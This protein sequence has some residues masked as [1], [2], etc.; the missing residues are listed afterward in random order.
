M[1]WNDQQLTAIAGILEFI[2]KP[3]DQSDPTGWAVLLDGFAGTGK[4]TLVQEALNQAITLNPKLQVCVTAP[5]NRATQVLR[6]FGKDAGINVDS[7]TIH[8]LLGLLLGSEGEARKCFRGSEGNFGQYHIVIIDEASIE[9]YL[10]MDTTTESALKY[11]VKVVF[12]GD[13]CQLNPPKESTSRVFDPKEVP[14]RFRLTINERVDKDSPVNQAIVASRARVQSYLDIDTAYNEKVA[15]MSKDDFKAQERKLL[16]EKSIAYQN[17]PIPLEETKLTEN[18]DGV[19]I[20]QGKE[21]YD[22]MLDQFDCEEFQNDI[23]FCR[24]LAWTNREVDRLNHM[25][26]QRIYG[27]CCADFIIGETL[28]IL[29]PVLDTEGVPVIFTDEE[30]VIESIGTGAI[31][32]KDDFDTLA[33]GHPKYVVWVLQLR[34]PDNRGTHRIATLHS[35]SIY[36]FNGRL[37][38]LKDRAIKKTGL[39]KKFYQFKEL[40]TVVRPIYAQTVH[41]AQGQTFNTTFLQ[42]RDI[43]KNNNLLEQ[44][45]LDYV[46]KSRTTTNLVLN[47]KQ[48]R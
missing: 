23:T 36:N 14:T 7:G 20:I 34:L 39:W 37:K 12:M 45:R 29:T 19:H 42:C 30:C 11:G 43:A 32:D 16:R 5:T 17:V 41:K 1:K 46:G 38:R 26:R 22:T 48:L 15:L 33:E 28:S 35:D 8:S 13:I 44:A 4:T 9:G 24:V 47:L 27:K 18:G 21:F 3:F 31:T 40:F 10:L 25:I 6:D 2:K